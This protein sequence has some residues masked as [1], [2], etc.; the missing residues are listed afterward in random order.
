MSD[1]KTPTS[2]TAHLDLDN[3]CCTFSVRH[4]LKRERMANVLERGEELSVIGIL[5]RNRP[6]P[7]RT[8]VPTGAICAIRSRGAALLVTGRAGDGLTGGR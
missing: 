6:I 7:G 3:V 2:S 5:G 1:T 4:D 8:A